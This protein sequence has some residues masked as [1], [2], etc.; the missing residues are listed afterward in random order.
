MR[1]AD[2]R[3]SVGEHP[4][5]D[6][7]DSFPCAECLG[8][9]A[10]QHVR[11]ALSYLVDSERFPAESVARRERSAGVVDMREFDQ[12]ARGWRL[13]VTSRPWEQRQKGLRQW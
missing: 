13:I 6:P 7:P 4:Q 1:Y 11:D 3:L 12:A 9:E 10:G 2:S 8:D 5:M